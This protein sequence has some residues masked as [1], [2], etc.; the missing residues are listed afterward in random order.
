MIQSTVSS[1]AIALSNSRR[2]IQT[3]IDVEQA[4][5]EEEE[6]DSEI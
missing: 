2:T 6:S 1:Q 3:M 4:M 5:I